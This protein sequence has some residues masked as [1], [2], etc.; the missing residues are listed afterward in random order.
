MLSQWPH[1]NDRALP[2][3]SIVQDPID[4]EIS[5]RQ[6]FA[7]P[8]VFFQLNPLT[9]LVCSDFLRSLTSLRLRIPGRQLVRF[10]C[11]DPRSLPALE[12][13]DM[14]T[15]LMLESE[16]EALLVRFTTLRHLILDGCS[17]KRLDVVD[18]E[19]VALGKNCSLAGVKRAKEREKKLRAWLE[20]N[21]ARST[22]VN[23]DQS[24][25]EIFDFNGQGGTRRPR[26]GRRGLATAAI[27]LRESSASN[28]TLSPFV[29]VVVNIPTARIRILPPAPSLTSLAITISSQI[30]PDR[31]TS[32]RADFGRGWAEGLAQLTAIRNRLRQ[33]WQNG[34]RLVRFSEEPCASEEGL[35]GLVDAGSEADFNAIDTKIPLLCLAGPGRKEGHTEGCG[36]A[37]GWD[38]WKEDL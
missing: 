27:S 6:H 32:V 1:S 2:S 34:I 25:T 24:I 13:L 23:E 29:P 16:V 14:S 12:F 17:I 4:P 37:I 15:C 38:V 28:N 8:L 31:H 19:W 21:T 7:Q 5:Q 26:R 33:S 20:A 9:T 35:D 3:L 18:G 36:H 11:A 10:L 30:S 22:V